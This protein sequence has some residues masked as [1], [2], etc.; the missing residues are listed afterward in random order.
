[1]NRIDFQLL[2][3]SID[4]PHFIQMEAGSR[5]NLRQEPASDRNLSYQQTEENGNKCGWSPLQGESNENNT[6]FGLS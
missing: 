5:L 4:I 2:D 1:M 6:L 3:K